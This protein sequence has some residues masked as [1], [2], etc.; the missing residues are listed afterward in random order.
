M[1]RLTYR[2]LTYRRLWS[3]PGY[4]NE[5][6]ELTEEFDKSTPLEDNFRDLKLAVERL[7]QLSQE[8]EMDWETERIKA[9][10]Q[11]YAVI[12]QDLGTMKLKVEEMTKLQGIPE[13]VKA[14]IVSLNQEIGGKNP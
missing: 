10:R 6:I 13:R 3:L 11:E 7:H 5:S 1:R 8:T 12:L 4:Q 14:L 9:M 2:R